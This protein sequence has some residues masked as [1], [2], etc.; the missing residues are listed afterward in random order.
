MSET[1]LA[2]YAAWLAGSRING[3]ELVPMSYLLSVKRQEEM[4]FPLI[5][6]QT[7]K[8]PQTRGKEVYKIWAI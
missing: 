6:I 1:R 8:A 7:K 5:N 3:R 2:W 4:D